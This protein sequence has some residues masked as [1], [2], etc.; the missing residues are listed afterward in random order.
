MSK[1]LK[2]INSKNIKMGYRLFISIVKLIKNPYDVSPIFKVSEFRNHQSF[3]LALAKAKADPEL[4]KLFQQRYR[5]PKAHDLEELSKC[6]EGSLGKVFATHMNHFNMS[7]VFYPEM[8]DSKEDDLTYL[9]Y[10]SRETHDIHHAVLGMNPDLLG[11]M[12]ISAYYLSQLNIPL[13]AVLLGVGFLVATIKKPFMIDHLVSSIIKGWTM[14][15]A[16]KNILAVRWEDMW[17]RPMSEVREELGVSVENETYENQHQREI[18][19]VE[20]LNA[21]KLIES[22]NP[23]NVRA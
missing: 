11:E 9:R 7:V 1:I 2:S 5:S 15:K 3:Q 10:R 6:S 19:K 17:D 22:F 8:D 4:A 16:S 20:K 23:T 14:G 18:E 13:S 21:Q 12:S